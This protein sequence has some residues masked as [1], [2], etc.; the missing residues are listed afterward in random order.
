MR[1]KGNLI[2]D[3]LEDYT[4]IDIETT[5]TVLGFDEIIEIGALKIRNGNI[6]EKLD[7][8]VKP[9]NLSWYDSSFTGIQESELLQAKPIKET[10]N[11]FID[12]I[13]N[14]VLVGANINSF[15]INFLYDV[16]YNLTNKKTK[17]DMIDIFTFARRLIVDMQYPSLK[18]LCEYFKIQTVFHRALADC[19]STYKIYELFKKEIKG[20]NIDLIDFKKPKVIKQ[21]VSF[22][23]LKEEFEEIDIDNV[24]YHKK[25]AITG[26]FSISQTEIMQ[27][28]RN[29]GGEPQNGF[30]SETNI[31]IVGEFKI[32]NGE[33]QKGKVPKA[34]QAR[35]KGKD[36]ITIS[37]KEFFDY[38]NDYLNTIKGKTND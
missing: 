26:N 28:V 6:I 29:M 11:L 30:T 33:R 27:I 2:F 21:K 32:V 15:D 18:K 10:I 19:E 7:F 4:V 1:E 24:F 14:D 37:E 22:S 12:F 16:I 23:D 8:L 36:V 9:E 17:N 3:I 34:Q 25:V 5:G 20:R 35:L 13:G 38:K 31:L